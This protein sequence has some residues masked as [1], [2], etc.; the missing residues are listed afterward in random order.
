MLI[1]CKGKVIKV[2]NNED[3]LPH[4]PFIKASD[5]KSLLTS[6]IELRFAVFISTSSKKNILIPGDKTKSKL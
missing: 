3:T 4:I 5:I 6:V 2:L 1:A